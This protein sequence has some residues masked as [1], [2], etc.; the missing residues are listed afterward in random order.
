M[1]LFHYS[2]ENSQVPQIP[3]NS[4]L[5]YYTYNYL[6]YYSKDQRKAPPKSKEQSLPTSQRSKKSK[7]QLI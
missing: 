5:F 6:H 3:S 1:I 7:K 4:S 2:E